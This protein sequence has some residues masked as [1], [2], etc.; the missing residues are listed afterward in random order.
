MTPRVN[1]KVELQTLRVAE[2]SEKQLY[3]TLK[4]IYGPVRILFLLLSSQTCKVL[5]IILICVQDF[6]LCD[7]SEFKDKSNKNLSKQFWLER[8]NL[9]IKGVVDYSSTENKPK[10][11]DQ[12]TRQ[13]ATAR[14]ESYRYIL[15][16]A[17]TAEFIKR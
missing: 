10:T 8:G 12:I 7:P 13:F 17:F 15:F 5:Y 6:K 1:R 4:H 9:V 11:Q 16:F 3:E 14:L 2:E